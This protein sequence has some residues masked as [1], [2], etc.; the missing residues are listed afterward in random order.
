[1]GQIQNAFLQGLGVIS[2]AAQMYRLTDQYAKGNAKKQLNELQKKSDI[3]SARIATVADIRQKGFSEEQYNKFKEIHKNLYSTPKE[4]GTV[5]GEITKKIKALTN[6]GV[7][8]DDPRLQELEAEQ[9]F[10]KFEFPSGA[11]IKEF[12]QAAQMSTL[13]PAYQEKLQKYA[14]EQ[15]AAKA[16]KGKMKDTAQGGTV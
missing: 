14:E 8:P 10:L 15:A 4:V 6:T 2:Q 13:A 3:T 1:M 12:K 11:D 16:R 9:E 5:K 7:K